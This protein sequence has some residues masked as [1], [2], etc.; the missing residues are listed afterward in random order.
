[1]HA[2]T[3]V[4][5]AKRA[6]RRSFTEAVYTSTGID[7]TL[8]SDIRATLTER[9]NY[10]CVYC[11]HWR[12]DAYTPEMTLL[13]W[14][15][16]LSSVRSYVGHYAVQFLG[17]EPMIMPWFSDLAMFC[18]DARIDWGVVTNGSSLSGPRVARIAEARPLNVDV[19]ID[20][21]SE[22][23]NDTA[24]GIVGAMRR[25]SQ[26][27]AALV[28]ARAAAGANFP[29]RLKTVVTRQNFESL[30]ELVGWA[31]GMPGVLVD[32]SP[33]R[34]WRPEEIAAHY[35]VAGPEMDALERRIEH[36]K[37]L[38]RNGAP[39]ETS[40]AK[41][42]AIV[43]HFKG[44]PSVHGVGSCRV[45]LRSLDIRPNGDVNHCWKFEKVG[46]L[47]HTSMEDIWRDA[48]RRQIVD[49]TLAC[50]LFKTTCSMSCMAHRTLGQDIRRGLQI[51]R[52]SA[53]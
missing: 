49:D 15:G 48:N 29:I 20:S 44:E 17:G 11:Q 34:L 51:A 26:G 43:P 31:Q 5:L 13:E 1:M 50:D 39:I 53:R 42:E 25:V 2:T 36:L 23:V 12:Q 14:Q 45:G 24:R 40:V 16:V 41:L 46:N 52:V 22:A 6:S 7:R 21:R 8:P 27:V 33:V 4:R 47:R 19:S 35:P 37:L 10:R 38:K 28:E 32:F 3:F 9:C 30:S 18:R